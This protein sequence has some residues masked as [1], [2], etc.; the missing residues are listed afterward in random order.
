MY[1]LACDFDLITMR[2]GVCEL[3]IIGMNFSGQT[4]LKVKLP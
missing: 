1:D 2:K 4:H 3:I